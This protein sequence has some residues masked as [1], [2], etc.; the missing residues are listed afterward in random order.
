MIKANALYFL[1]SS[2]S[3][4]LFALMR[5]LLPEDLAHHRAMTIRWRLYAAAY[6]KKVVTKMTAYTE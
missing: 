6:L 5:L 4:N 1:I 2:L 3:Y